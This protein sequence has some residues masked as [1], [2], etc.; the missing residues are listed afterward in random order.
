LVNIRMTFSPFGCR[1]FTLVEVLVTVLL[2]SLG[3][4]GTALLQMHALQA[5]HSAYHRSLASLFAAD[6]AERVRKRVAS[7]SSPD[8]WLEDWLHHRDCTLA[9]GHVCLPG[10]Q[11][12]LDNHGQRWTIIVSWSESRFQEPGSR[13]ALDYVLDLS[14]EW[15]P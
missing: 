4:L 10:L 2:L 9:T 1:G 8:A 13:S 6:A 11:V 3:A 14:W 15:S 7:G 12:E 5:T